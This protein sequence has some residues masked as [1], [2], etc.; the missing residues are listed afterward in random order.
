[1][2]KS[3]KKI[4]AL[5][6]LEVIQWFIY[7]VLGAIVLVLNYPPVI[8]ETGAIGRYANTLSERYDGWFL[9]PSAG[10]IFVV[11]V[12]SIA[13]SVLANGFVWVN[14]SG[15]NLL[16]T[17]VIFM[18][19]SYLFA[20]AST[21]MFFDWTFP[22]ITKALAKKIKDG[23]LTSYIT[24]DKGVDAKWLWI[25]TIVTGLA[26]A[27]GIVATI[28]YSIINLLGLIMLGYN[29]GTIGIF[30]VYARILYLEETSTSE[31]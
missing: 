5:L 15:S 4:M 31:P 9:H 12:I 8:C 20:S 3:G 6:N 25:S 7:S 28:L 27:F 17:G 2:D 29:I 26:A 14:D 19:A 23:N 11:W 18:L 24:I 10:W 13:C 16:L 22:R 30:I 21:L 1:L